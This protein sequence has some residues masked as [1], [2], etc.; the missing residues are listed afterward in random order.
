MFTTI[1][2]LSGLGALYYYYQ[3]GGKTGDLL[4]RASSQLSKA[5]DYLGSTAV[6]KDQRRGQVSTQG[7]SMQSSRDI[8]KEISTSN[9]D[10]DRFPAT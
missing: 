10:L 2:V 1:L 4:N 9:V 5:K 8:G 3:R 6:D 7:Q